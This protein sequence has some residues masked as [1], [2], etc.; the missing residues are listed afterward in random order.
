MTWVWSILDKKEVLIGNLHQDFQLGMRNRHR[1]Y[2]FQRQP[3]GPRPF[4]WPSP[5]RAS[6]MVSRTLRR[7]LTLLLASSPLQL[8]NPKLFVSSKKRENNGNSCELTSGLPAGGGGG[9]GRIQAFALLFRL[10]SRSRTTPISFTLFCRPHL[11]WRIELS[12]RH[13]C[14]GW[15]FPFNCQPFPCSMREIFVIFQNEGL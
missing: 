14:Y 11:T 12:V 2:Y 15:S 10:K 8:P 1:H 5:Q 7:T 4:P 13:R 9:G 6:Q 3:P